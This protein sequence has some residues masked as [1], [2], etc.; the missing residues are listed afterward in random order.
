MT[1]EIPGVVLVELL[2]QFGLLGDERVE[3]RIGFGEFGVDFIEARQ[4]FDDG[5]APLLSRPR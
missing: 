5:S 1:V 4:H 2:L 3:V